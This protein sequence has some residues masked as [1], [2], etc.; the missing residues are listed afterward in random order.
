M[1]WGDNM[2]DKNIIVEILKKHPRGLKAKDIA[3]FIVGA[4][5]KAINQVLYANPAM[6]SCNSNYEWTLQSELNVN[7]NV[8]PTIVNTADEIKNCLPK[9]CVGNEA[10][11][12]L[13]RVDRASLK[14][15]SKRYLQLSQS[16]GTDVFSYVLNRNE[17]EDLMSISNIDFDIALARSKRL[18]EV[19]NIKEYSTWKALVFSSNFEMICQHIEK[20]KEIEKL[21]KLSSDVWLKVIQLSDEEFNDLIKRLELLTKAISSIFVNVVSLALDSNY[22]TIEKRVK[23]ISLLQKQKIFPSI[24]RYSHAWDT[25]LTVSEK[26]FDIYLKHSQKIY[27]EKDK[28]LYK[29]NSRYSIINS[30]EVIDIV[31][32]DEIPFNR[33]CDNISSYTYTSFVE[34]LEYEDW[35][36][37]FLQDKIKFNLSYK[38]TKK[39]D[40]AI[41][42]DL[43]KKPS[44]EEWKIFAWLT[45]REFTKELENKK[46][47]YIDYK[48]KKE[49]DERIGREISATISH[50]QN[51]PLRQCT[52]DC[53]TCRRQ[54]CPL[55]K[56]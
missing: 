55:D 53:S 38:N 31:L 10:L 17:L 25:L 19:A 48:V 47:E 13:K 1:T 15:V 56:K 35:K 27:E 12:F 3:D 52:G 7:R 41:S 16:I 11:E 51:N 21:S 42:D 34:S 33:F 37:F 54:E 14:L 6:F 32:L 28:I 46:Q 36:W 39:I 2:I 43:I 45:S 9:S 44:K 8:S 40:K 4:D 22:K 20:A 23:T 50:Y 49:E 5:R 18:K 24:S 26:N 30:R 29:I